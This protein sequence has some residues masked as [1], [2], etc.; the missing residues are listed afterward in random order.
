MK[1]ILYILILLACFCAPILAQET[2]SEQETISREMFPRNGRLRSIVRQE[3][4]YRSG[5]RNYSRLHPDYRNNGMPIGIYS[6]MHYLFGI[7][8]DGG[9]SMPFSLT[10]GMLQGE[11]GSAHTV[12]LSFDVQNR[13]IKA[14]IGLGYRRQTLSAG[15]Q[16]LTMYDHDVKDAWGYQYHLR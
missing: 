13:F 6:A 10:D 15:V 4:L 1:R 5:L 9:F 16:A 3:I 2:D 14:Q 8:G 7:W 11:C 12:G